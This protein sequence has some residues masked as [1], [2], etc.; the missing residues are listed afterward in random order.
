M[1]K[2]ILSLGVISM[3]YSCL[4]YIPCKGQ[5]Y[6]IENITHQELISRFNELREKYPEYCAAGQDYANEYV[7]HYYV[8]L[9][10]KG[11]LTV[12]LDVFIGDQI[13]NPPTHLAFT[14]VWSSTESKQ[15]NSK[16]LDKKLNE[17]YK[18]EF[19]TEILDKLGLKWKRKSCW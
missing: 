17:Q 15:I 11:N 2:I 19:E 3:F 1:K 14:D 7:P 18:K 16:E 12:N 9:K 6:V 13:P 5:D 4:N 10:L 8:S